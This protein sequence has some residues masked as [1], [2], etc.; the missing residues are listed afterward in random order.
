MKS[1]IE[2]VE[3][4]AVNFQSPPK[5]RTLYSSFLKRPVKLEVIDYKI[6]NISGE[7]GLLF[8]NDGQDLEKMRI[9]KS[10]EHL[11]LLGAIIPTTIV[12]IMAGERKSEYGVAGEPD[13]LGRGSKA[14]LYNDFII[15]ELMPYINAITG[16]HFPAET[17]AFAGCS[18][19][20]LSALDI[21][22]SNPN[23]FGMAGVFSGSLW[24]RRRSYL[25]G[26]TDTDRIIHD[27]VNQTTLKDHFRCW[28][29]A[30]TCDERNDR[31]RSGVADAVE[32]TLDMYE[33]LSGKMKDPSKNLHLRIINEGGHNTETWADHF[34]DFIHHCFGKHLY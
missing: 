12:S 27:K 4:Q 19:G 9:C 31:N 33:L 18:L 6:N 34:P 14:G 26:Y 28:L 5:I 21:V 7:K 22:I 30:G 24:W 17:T 20:G 8:L 10:V 13:Y 16:V 32:D 23:H 3:N 25:E 1:I 15:H 29:M 2:V 11:S